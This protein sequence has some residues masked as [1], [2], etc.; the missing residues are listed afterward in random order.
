MLSICLASSVRRCFLPDLVSLNRYTAYTKLLV[1]GMPSKTFSMAALPP[2]E[3]DPSSSRRDTILK[4]SRERFSQPRDMVEEK[5]KR[6]SN[7]KSAGGAGESSPRAEAQVVPDASSV[8]W[9]R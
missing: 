3:I 5:I 2:V 4:I 8:R 1:E 9:S 7:N 6:W